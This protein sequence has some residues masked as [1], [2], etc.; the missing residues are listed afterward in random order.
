MAFTVRHELSDVD[1]DDGGWL[2]G[3]PN[4][5]PFDIFGGSIF[6]VFN[7]FPRGGSQVPTRRSPVVPVVIGEIPE[8]WDELEQLDPELFEPI[9]ETRPGHIPDPYPGSDAATVVIG[10]PQG[11]DTAEQNDVGEEE[12]AHDWGHL[13]RQGA[14]AVFGLD[15]APSVVQGGFAPN[16]FVPEQPN[17]VTGA[18]G[19]GGAGG[20]CDGMAWAG[21]A[22]PKGYKVVRDSCGNGVLRKVRRRRRRRMLTSGDKDDIASIVSMVGKGQMAAALING[23]MRR[24]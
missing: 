4:P 1:R 14:S 16:A 22:P 6:D 9:L 20:D 11:V 12:V 10:N 18:A 7:P 19:G 23:S 8:T 15:A 5:F 24:G 2:F 17:V 21:G 13:I 3:I